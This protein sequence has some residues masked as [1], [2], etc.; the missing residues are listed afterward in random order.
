MANRDPEKIRT[1]L[2]RQVEYW[3]AGKKEEMFALYR[4]IAPGRISIEYVGLPVLE[5]WKALED[6]WERFAG[7]VHIDV[8]EVLVTGQEAACYHHNTTVG[9][10]Q[11]WRPSIELYRFDGDDVQIRYFHTAQL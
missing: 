8:I 11:P 7:K 10:G 1:F 9:S 4:G 2:H 6:M 3:N 5:G